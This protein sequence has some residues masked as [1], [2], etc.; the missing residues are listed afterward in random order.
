[1]T[2]ENATQVTPRPSRWQRRMWPGVVTIVGLAM[3]TGA[4]LTVSLMLPRPQVCAPGMVTTVA[5]HAQSVPTGPKPGCATQQSEPG[6]PSQSA[7]YEH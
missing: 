5:S 6:K 4:L 1:M 3:V 2:G 7:L